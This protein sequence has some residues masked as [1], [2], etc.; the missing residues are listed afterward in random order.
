MSVANV[1]IYIRR[2]LYPEEDAASD[3]LR[4]Q[5]YE[6]EAASSSINL[7]SY[8]EITSSTPL[9][10]NGLHG[11][12]SIELYG[13]LVCNASPDTLSK[14]NSIGLNLTG[15]AKT[16]WF[17]RPGFLA[18]SDSTCLYRFKSVILE[19][20]DV[21]P[22]ASRKGEFRI[23]FA[24]I[25]RPHEN[26]PISFK[27]QS[28]EINYTLAFKFITKDL[29]NA[30]VKDVRIPVLV[31]PALIGAPP[32]PLPPPEF[33]LRED[34][35]GTPV[36]DCE[37]AFQGNS[38]LQSGCIRPR[39]LD[40]FSTTIPQ[41][42]EIISKPPSLRHQQRASSARTASLR[43]PAA[44]VNIFG[45]SFKRTLSFETLAFPV[46]ESQPLPYTED[47]PLSRI[48]VS[49]SMDN[50]GQAGSLQQQQQQQQQHRRQRGPDRIRTSRLSYSMNE[51]S[52]SPLEFSNSPAT[53]TNNPLSLEN[54]AKSTTP[55]GLR[56]QNTRFEINPD[57]ESSSSST[58]SDS[59]SES[60]IAGDGSGGGSCP[61]DSPQS[62][63]IEH[64]QMQQ[65]ATSVLAETRE[66]ALD[67]KSMPFRSLSLLGTR[68]R[69]KLSNHP[70][71]RSVYRLTAAFET[72]PSSKILNS[73]SLI[74]LSHNKNTENVNS[75]N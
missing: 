63:F 66:A 17:G 33:H 45:N 46:H 6:E 32:P 43:G 7:D 9:I 42:S 30:T 18:Y 55:L 61:A 49:P 21:F 10:L 31:V 22:A 27:S 53:L 3:P 73:N 39:V 2:P 11:G 56:R 8:R 69:Q 62:I 70:G 34:S 24:A 48:L 44:A 72:P 40:N 50:L 59:D 26:L 16:K 14:K 37:G 13:M 29:F 47:D 4:L 51:S 71:D 20:S 5:D 52:M 28:A 74:T 64:Q 1:R 41:Q 57:K 65:R 36:L 12:C 19:E 25:I 68:I 54:V 38:F 75:L 23:P 35:E 67:H 60:E 58:A 15:M